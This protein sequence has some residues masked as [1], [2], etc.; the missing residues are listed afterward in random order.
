MR[1]LAATLTLLV[2]ALPLKAAD[3]DRLMAALQLSA[4]VDIMRAEGLRYGG[5]VGDEMLSAAERGRWDRVLKRVYEAEA[6]LSL[7]RANFTEAMDGVDTAPLLAFFE[8]QGAEIVTL[9]IAARRALLDD[10][11]ETAAEAR[12]AELAAG[13]ARLVDQVERLISDSDLVERNVSGALN[14]N[15]DFYRGLSVEGGLDLSE[16]EILADIWAQE[17]EMRTQTRDW[18]Q[19]YLTM[20][21][22]PM[23]PELLDA[24]IKLYQSPEGRALN[25]GLFEAFDAMYEK[26]SYQL[27]RAVALQMK[28]ED[29]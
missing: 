26:L 14:A 1:F 9:E 15:L 7:V 2:L 5:D 8:G 21:Y 4:T 3:I 18:M 10:E 29:L 23:P 13:G 20:A 19:A 12:Y 24:Y 11:V 25:N 16:S 27:G 28:G 17:E 22:Q 6:M